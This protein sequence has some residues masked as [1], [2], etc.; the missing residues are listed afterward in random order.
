M[1]CTS[2]YICCPHDQTD[3]GWFSVDFCFQIP[4]VWCGRSENAVFKFP[5]RSDVEGAGKILRLPTDCRKNA[6]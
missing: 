5:L 2:D 6:R 4:P 1:V 3:V